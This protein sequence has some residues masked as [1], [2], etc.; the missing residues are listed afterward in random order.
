[1]TTFSKNENDKTNETDEQLLKAARA[2]AIAY[3]TQSD[4]DTWWK[5][6]LYNGHHPIIGG[7]AG[8]GVNGTHPA[9]RN[10]DV[11]GKDVN[12]IGLSPFEPNFG[13]GTQNESN[14]GDYA[15]KWRCRILDGEEELDQ[16]NGLNDWKKVA[17]GR[18]EVVQRK[19]KETGEMLDKRLPVVAWR[20]FGEDIELQDTI[21]YDDAADEWEYTLNEFG[22]TI[23][24][25]LIEDEAE[26]LVWCNTR[27]MWVTQAERKQHWHDSY[28][29]EKQYEAF[30]KSWVEKTRP[31]FNNGIEMRIAKNTNH[32]EINKRAREAGMVRNPRWTKGC[33]DQP[34]HIPRGALLTKAN[35]RVCNPGIGKCECEKPILQ[36]VRRVPWGG[37]EK[38][39]KAERYGFGRWMNL[40]ITTQSDKDKACWRQKWWGMKKADKKTAIPSISRRKASKAVSWDSVI[41]GEPKANTPKTETKPEQRVEVQRQSR[42][43]EW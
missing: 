1:M 17:T 29:M 16:S 4:N 20:Y 35:I 24:V 19:C 28:D 3:F 11:Y 40:T 13:E 2:D 43:V 31:I 22:E 34:Y 37:Y 18:Y 9:R 32:R 7:G 30:E 12:G 23:S 5:H 25:K 26:T 39:H 33:L 8:S 27:G 15:V 42:V 21:D 6:N 41:P 14:E 36:R 38:G 10:D